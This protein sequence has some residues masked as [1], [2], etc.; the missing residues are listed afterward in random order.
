MDLFPTARLEALRKHQGSGH[1]YLQLL[2]SPEGARLRD[3]LSKIASQA[4]TALQQRWAEAVDSEDIRRFFQGYSE[5][6]TAAFLT[7][8]G[9]RIVD[10]GAPGPSLLLERTIEDQP[11]RSRVLVLAF[12]QP[13]R[14][15]EETA[16]MDLLVRS[17]NRARARHRIAVLV[18]RWHPHPFDPEP[19]RRAVDLWLRKV[20]RGQWEGRSA[21]YE[22]DHIALEFI[23]TERTTRAGEGSVAFAMGPLDGFRTLEVVETRLVFELDAYR[24]KA[25]SSEPLIV[26]LATNSDW[27]L[28]PGF[29]RSMLYGCPTWHATNGLPQRQEMAFG[30]GPGPALFRDP[31]YSGVTAAI[32]MDQRSGRG[33]CARAYLN[34]WT[35]QPVR[36]SIAACATFGVDRWESDAPVMRWF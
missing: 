33:P 11:E 1:Q 32:I 17:L 5:L 35:A 12:I 30:K 27:A 31:V 22:D 19:I 34:P 9:W 8:A 3:R 23:L 25:E 7:E 36:R 4:P 26:S 2:T 18:R 6:T 16:A 13:G 29:L 20:A 15:S 10:H 28:S 21:A 24:Q 14:T